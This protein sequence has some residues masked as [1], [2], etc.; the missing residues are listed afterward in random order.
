MT[1]SVLIGGGRSYHSYSIQFC[2]FQTRFESYDQN[3]L[4]FTSGMFSQQLVEPVVSLVVP[5]E[6]LFG[7]NIKRFTV[8]Y[9]VYFVML[10]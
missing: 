1:V 9:I 6:V 7:L 3:G 5:H 10:Q 4:I 2:Q 8:V